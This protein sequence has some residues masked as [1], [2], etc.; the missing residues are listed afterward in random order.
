MILRVQLV[1]ITFAIP[2]RQVPTIIN[3]SNYR[4]MSPIARRIVARTHD[5]NPIV[6]IDLIPLKTK[7]F[8]VSIE[9]TNEDKYKAV[10][11][12]KYLRCEM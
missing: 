4:S 9:H 1:A 12:D 10:I 6:I 11:A 5:K 7:A 2:A 8:L 3:E